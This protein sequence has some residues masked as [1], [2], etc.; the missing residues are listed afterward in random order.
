MLQPSPLANP[1][2]YVVQ[3]TLGSQGWLYSVPLGYAPSLRSVKNFS[4]YNDEWLLSS[5]SSTLS[6]DQNL[7]QKLIKD[8]NN[9]LVYDGTLVT[10][11]TSFGT[12]NTSDTSYSTRDILS[13]SPLNTKTYNDVRECSSWS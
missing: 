8:V 11:M 12:I 10:G 9:A 5:G 3:V 7:N 6:S 1:P 4:T 13:P 2:A